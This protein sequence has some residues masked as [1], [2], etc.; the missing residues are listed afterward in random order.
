MPFES[1]LLGPL[2]SAY[3]T[4]SR[5]FP[6]LFSGDIQKNVVNTILEVIDS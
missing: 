1:Y 5:H 6:I 3:N 4:S 2:P